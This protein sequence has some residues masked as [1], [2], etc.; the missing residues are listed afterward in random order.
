MT[1]LDPGQLGF[2]GFRN[3]AD[4][5]YDRMTIANAKA[6]HHP[7]VWNLLSDP[8]RRVGVIG[9]GSTGVQATPV[10]ARQ[11]DHLFLS[12]RSASYTMPAARTA[13]GSR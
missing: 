10:V 4:H 12:Q 8:G 3:R 6:V 11:A 1:G 5:S 9:T 7:R 13:A 2:Y